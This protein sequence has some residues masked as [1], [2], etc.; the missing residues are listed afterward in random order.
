VCVYPA[1]A[2]GLPQLSE[3]FVALDAKL[4][5]T[6]ASRERAE[7]LDRD[8]DL[9]PTANAGRFPLDGLSPAD[10]R[11]ATSEYLNSLAIGGP[12]CFDRQP[13]DT[14]AAANVEVVRAWLLD[15]RS[16]MI[17]PGP[18]QT[19]ALAWFSGL[20]ESQRRVWFRSNYEAIVS[21]TLATTAFGA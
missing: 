10:L 9:H 3:L 16:E 13:I 12:P 21:C 5:G 7:Q 14:T 19:A 6:P 11:Q 1:Y 2:D 20:T 4:A 18:D 8:F 15:D 17:R